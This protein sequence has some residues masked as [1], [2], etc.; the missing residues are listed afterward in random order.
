MV[1]ARAVKWTSATS[2]PIEIRPDFTGG[3]PKRYPVKPDDLEADDPSQ[4]LA[5]LRAV[6]T[7]PEGL[8]P[9]IEPADITKKATSHFTELAPTIQARCD[10]PEHDRYRKCS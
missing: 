9:R 1:A 4:K 3:G 8:R 10:D 2:T 6:F 5:I 7:S